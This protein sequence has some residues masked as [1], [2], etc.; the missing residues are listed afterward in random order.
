MTSNS[1]KVTWTSTFEPPS[2]CRH[3][4]ENP[5]AEANPFT[6][7][8]SETSAWFRQQASGRV[9]YEVGSIRRQC[10]HQWW[11]G[12]SRPPLCNTNHIDTRS[13]YIWTQSCGLEYFKA[14]WQAWEQSH[15]RGRHW[16]KTTRGKLL[17]K[18]EGCKDAN[19]P[20]EDLRS[21]RGLWRIV[22]TCCFRRS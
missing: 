9:N 3:S 8:D 11:S 22:R 7:W 20:Q 4:A 14:T 18:L 1:E 15:G 6:I 5:L 17:A 19:A 21:G 2:I 12:L 10:P 13:G 16:I